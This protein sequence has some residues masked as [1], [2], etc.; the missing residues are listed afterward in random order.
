[1]IVGGAAVFVGAAFSWVPSF[2]WDEAATVSAANRPLG[3]LLELHAQ[4]DAVHGLHNLLLHWWFSLV[5]ISEFTARIPGAVALG[6]GAAAITATGHKLGGARVAVASGVLFA[7]TPRVTWAATEARSYA[8]AIA[9]AALL[10]LLLV[11]ALTAGHARWWVAYALLAAVST[12]LFVYSAT[13]VLAHAV[14]VLLLSRDRVRFAVAAVAGASLSAPFMMLASTQIQQ[15]SWIPP[16]DATVVRTILVDQWFPQ[17]PWAAGLCA[18]TVVAGAVVAMRIGVTPGERMLLAVALP[19]FAVPMTVLLVSSLVSRN[20][21][22]DRYLS[23]TVP[24]MVL[25]VGWALA[26]VAT[27]WWTMLVV[28]VALAVAVSPAYIAQRQP[29]GKAG[30]MDYS[31]V[32]DR[33]IEVSEAGDCVAFEPTISWA[34]TSPRAVMDARPDSVVGLDDVG[35]GRSAAERTQLW[36]SDAAPSESAVRAAARCTVLWVIADR[37]RDTP[38][39]LWHPNNVW[40][41]FEPYR[42]TDTETF[43]ELA[44]AGFEI[45]DHAAVHR[46]QLIRLQLGQTQ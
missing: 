44:A 46:L 22:L 11:K 2:W 3:A 7:I 36:S 1:M 10:T 15:V 19:G 42:F 4:R 28:F 5:G 9:G 16:L 17:A 8:F 24:A 39:K 34:P 32:A 12:V 13:V 37:E 40:W 43:H 14:T 35:L 21:Y 6:V 45:T 23:F 38:W 33:L 25:L 27:R 26:R 31:A 30:G 20:L 41:R 29:F 18:V